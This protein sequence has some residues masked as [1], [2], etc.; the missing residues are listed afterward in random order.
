MHE[1]KYCAEELS[2]IFV[3]NLQNYSLCNETPCSMHANVL[4]KCKHTA[5]IF[6][7]NVFKYIETII[8]ISLER[9]F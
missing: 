5:G 3:D 2:E 9:P 8:E 1:M 4:L 7:E 6:P